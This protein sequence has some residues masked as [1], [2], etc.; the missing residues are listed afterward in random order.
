MF[1]QEG[2]LY[3][4]RTVFSGI[5]RPAFPVLVQ[6]LEQT[7]RLIVVPGAC[8]AFASCKLFHFEARFF[9]LLLLFIYYYLI[10]YTNIS[11]LFAMIC[12]LPISS[13]LYSTGGGVLSGKVGTGMCGPDRVLFRPL[14]FTNCPFLFEN[15]FRYR[16]HFWKM[17][18]FQWIFP[19]VY[20]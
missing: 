2:L 17:Q 14:R 10:W 4:F 16:S 1:C 9:F 15:W 8:N 13:G 11:I 6:G 3:V 18:K 20:L 12:F 19:L 5:S 7:L